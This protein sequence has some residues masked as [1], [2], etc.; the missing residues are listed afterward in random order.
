[1]EDNCSFKPCLSSGYIFFNI[2]ALSDR[3]Q[4]SLLNLQQ[5]ISMP[6]TRFVSRLFF[7]KRHSPSLSLSLLLSRSPRSTYN[8]LFLLFLLVAL[9]T[10]DIR[11]A[12]VLMQV[13]VPCLR[14]ADDNDGADGGGGDDG[15][16]DPN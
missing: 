13:Q 10:G 16:G 9:F 2:P 8:P 15:D 7:H 3:G 1:M 14:R 12:R 6:T 11:F 5:L 4:T